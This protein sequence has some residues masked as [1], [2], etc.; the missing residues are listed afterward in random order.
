MLG[1][2]VVAGCG[3]SSKLPHTKLD[4][5]VLEQRDLPKAFAAFANGPTAMLDTHGT[6]R[7]DPQRFGRE[8]GWVARFN[9]PGS[10]ATKGALVVVSTVDVFDSED[11]ARRDFDAYGRQFKGQIA[12]R[13]ARSLAVRDLGDEAAALTSVSAGPTRVRTFV[14]YWRHRN[15]TASVTAN[16]FDRNLSFADALALARRQ[17]EKLA[18]FD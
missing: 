11:G 12:N 5:L 17:Q 2:A 10:T 8:A 3:S 4:R 13:L 1:L 6:P 18:R 14:I 16:G 7:A 15:G 9:R